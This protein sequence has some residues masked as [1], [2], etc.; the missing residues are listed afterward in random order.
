MISAD[1]RIDRRRRQLPRQYRSRMD[2]EL[3]E[4]QRAIQD[5]ARAFARDEMMPFA[6]AMGRGRDSSR[7]TRCARPR[8][9][10]SAA[11]TSGA[12]VG[13]SALTRLDAAHHLRGAGA[14]LHLDRRLHLDPQ[15]GGVDDR[16]LRLD[17]SCGGAF[18]PISAAWQQF[19]SYCL[20]EPDSGSDAA[21]LKTRAVR[22][23]RS[24]RARRHQGVHLGRRRLRRLPGDGAHR[25]RAGRA[26]SPASWS[27]RARRGS[28]SARRKRSSA[29]TRS[30]P[31]W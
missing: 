27:R 20:T 23:A 1:R 8:R 7:S 22:D 4:E 12:D 11:S 6:R 21:S 30:R 17:A 18:C 16:R 3:S 5:T 2:F 19:A 14:G 13:G 15:H 9:S 25:A 28:P 24:L 26:A 29:G 10:A 31:P